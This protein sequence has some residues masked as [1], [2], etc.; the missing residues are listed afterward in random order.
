MRARC[1]K[2]FT[3]R[4][5]PFSLHAKQDMQIFVFFFFLPLLHEKT[6]FYAPREFVPPLARVSFLK[7]SWICPFWSKLRCFCTRIPLIVEGTLCDWNGRYAHITHV[8]VAIQFFFFFVI[9]FIK[10]RG[11]RQLRHCLIF[12]WI[13]ALGPDVAIVCKQVDEKHLIDLQCAFADCL[14]PAEGERII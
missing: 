7:C 4:R 12:F 6:R 11:I 13:F 10:R 1:S 8:D 5:L 14:S 9:A 3:L 2:K